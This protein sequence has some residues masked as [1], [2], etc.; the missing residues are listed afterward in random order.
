M[1]SLY[2]RMCIVFCSVILISSV[3]GFLASNLYYQQRVKPQ[4]DAKLTKMAIGLQQFIEA[5]PESVG[6]YL[7]STASLG[8]KMYLS[9]NAGD[10]RFYGLPFR[11]NDLAPGVLEKVLAGEVYHGVADFPSSPFITGFF[12]NQL[13]NT[14]GV[15]VQIE[16]NTYALFMRP[17]AEVQFGEL[18]SFFAVIIAVTI[19]LSMWFMMITVFHIV[20]PITRLTEA[21]KKISQGRY[22][23][24][25]Y[26]ARRDEIGQL[27][28]HFMA[29]SRELE[30][31]NRARQDFV[32]NVSHEIESP[33][34]SIQGFARA[35]RDEGLEPVQRSEYLGIIEEESRRLARLSSQL[36]TLSSL[37]YDGNALQKQPFELRPQLRQVLQLLEW[38]L[39]EG[40]LAVRMNVDDITLRGDAN[41]LHQVWMNLLSN[42]VRHTPAGGTITITATATGNTC[43][44]T[45]A[46]TGTGIAPAKLP[47]IFDRFYRADEARTR[48]HGSSGL[49]LSIAQSIVLAHGGVIEAASE[50]GAGTSFTVK[51]PLL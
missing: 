46:D 28:S 21:T 15:P 34:T 20:K 9:D 44:V 18:R 48:G 4:N 6:E 27:A 24:K 33:L 47:M 16:G 39:T 35:L 3:L 11:A 40:E 49:G 19:L 32:A 13:T 37:D 10:E 38:R 12:D 8:Y 51:L 30:R 5:H 31:T 29:M 23:I 17:D 43:T 25:L 36:L 14:I 26:T 41:L 2:F 42:A 1:K 50:P 45:V 7:L 22:D